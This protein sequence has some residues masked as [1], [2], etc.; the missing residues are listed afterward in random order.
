[1][2]HRHIMRVIACNKV[3][4]RHQQAHAWREGIF[5]VI[6]NIST[7]VVPIQIISR[8][9]EHLWR[10]WMPKPLFQVCDRIFNDQICRARF[11]RSC[12][13]TWQ[14]ILGK[15]QQEIFQI[16]GRAAQPILEAQ[17]KVASI[18][19]L[20]HRHIFKDLWQG[21]HNLEHTVL[22]R[23]PRFFFALP[24]KLRDRTLGLPQIFHTETAHFIQAH[25]LWHRWENH[26]GREAIAMGSYG[27]SDL[28]RKII[29]K[30]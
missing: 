2:H 21:L 22:K 20:V 27:E 28:S 18:L 3:S 15:H 14:I 16:F 8:S 9:L 13:D 11:F 17:H 12:L 23:T 30:N 6:G 5:H 26:T 4:S 10:E 25:H 24:H 7:R 19:S 29:N 1:M